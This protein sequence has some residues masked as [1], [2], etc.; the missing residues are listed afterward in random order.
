MKE[1]LKE[2]VIEN[3]LDQYSAFDLYEEKELIDDVI[4]AVNKVLRL[5][6]CV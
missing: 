6:E 4:S 3:L 5:N 1:L 2:E